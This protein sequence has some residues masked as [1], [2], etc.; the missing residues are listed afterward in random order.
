MESAVLD[1]S[2][3]DITAPDGKV[4][5]RATGSVLVF[6]GFLTL[7]QEGRD[8]ADDEEGQARLPKLAEHDALERG[9][10]ATEQHFPQPPPR[11]SEA[12]LVKKLEEL[13]IGRPST[14][15]SIIQVLQDR[16]Y[17][18][19]DQRRFMPEDRGR[20]VT[21]FLASFF[22]RYVEYGFTADLEGQL[23]DISGGRIDWRT[24]L[25]QFWEPFIAAVGG[26]KDLTIT[27]VIDALDEALGQHF[28]PA[29][30]NGRDPRLCPSCQS[31]RLG[32]RLGKSG[33]F[34]G[35]SNY[36]NC[37]HPPPLAPQTDGGPGHG[38]GT[39]LG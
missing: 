10:V 4:V 25:R 1:Q 39:H 14:Y 21:T 23:D 9:P 2:T 18:R 15:A 8:D 38:D 31:G 32:L 5:L 30:A 29:D 24:V 13:G 11:Y 36:P 34:I 22:E 7:Y 28:F 3:I 37:R 33:G 26:T 17:V 6:D 35:C 20:L 27:Q 12:S 16:N 19:L